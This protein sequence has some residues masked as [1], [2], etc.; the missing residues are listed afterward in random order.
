MSGALPALVDP[1]EDLTPA[2]A[3]RYSRHLLLPEIG[4]LGQRRLK[5]ARVLVVG[6]G[7]LGSPALLYLAAAGVGTIGIVDD[8]VVEESNL[9]RQ[10]AHRTE[11]VGRAKVDSA[12][13]AVARANPLVRVVHHRERF[14]AGSAARLVTAYD[15]VLDGSDNF[16]TRYLVNDAC[17]LA[18]TPWVWGRGAAL[19]RPGEHLLGPA[20]ADLPRPVPPAARPGDRALLRRGRRAGR[21]LRDGRLGDGDR[22][23]QAG[24][25]VR[26]QPVGA[27]A[28]ARR[29][30]HDVAHPGAAGR[31]HPPCRDRDHPP[32]PPAPRRDEPALPVIT[33]VELADRLRAREEGARD[34]LLVDVRE[35]GEHAAHA[36]PGALLVPLGDLLDGGG[37]A[38]V[39]HEL[40]WYCTA[41]AAP[42]PRGPCA[43]WS[44][45]ATP[46]WRT[47]PAASP[48]G[49]RRGW[50][51][52]QARARAG[53]RSGSS[54]RPG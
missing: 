48:H 15:L 4:V 52:S 2:E 36:I 33:P 7:G 11:D 39:P 51:P 3:R 23:R 42:A 1:G 17:V 14:T 50:G 26:A 25:R 49:R 47:W 22:G 32:P 30:E 10:V 40:P 9:Q 6:A 27:G 43:A 12:A 44:T 54:G 53:R 16:A 21:G 8:D 29:A 46:T 45:E 5:T 18:R 35:P 13:D 31:P 24:H 28:R 20:R 37:L 38:G 41:P 34:F 19:R